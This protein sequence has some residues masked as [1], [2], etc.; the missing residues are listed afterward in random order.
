[1]EQIIKLWLFTYEV[2]ATS[3]RSQ[4]E[5]AGMHIEFVDGGKGVLAITTFITQHSTAKCGA[6]PVHLQIRKTNIRTESTKYESF[7]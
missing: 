2:L 1:M 5:R 4:G 7:R 6:L 3:I